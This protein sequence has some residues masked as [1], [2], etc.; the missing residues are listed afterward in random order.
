MLLRLAS[1]VVYINLL[2]DRHGLVCQ[3]WSI[4]TTKFGI[5]TAVDDVYGGH[6]F[7]AQA[8]DGVDLIPIDD[9]GRAGSG[10]VSSSRGPHGGKVRA[11]APGGSPGDVLLEKMVNVRVR[12]DIWAGCF[13]L[14]IAFKGQAT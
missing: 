8:S 4:E 6:V 10:D 11:D 1:I 12:G 7:F 13:A 9:V 2:S 3:Q 5:V 14:S